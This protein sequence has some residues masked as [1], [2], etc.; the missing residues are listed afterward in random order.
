MQRFRHRI[1]K[2]SNLHE[3]SNAVHTHPVHAWRACTF[4]NV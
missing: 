1:Y 3:A 4:I 2:N